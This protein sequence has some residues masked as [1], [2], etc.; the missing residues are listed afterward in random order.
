MYF[1]VEMTDCT[2][3]IFFNVSYHRSFIILDS[4][5]TVSLWN[6]MLRK[7]FVE[8]CLEIYIRSPFDVYRTNQRLQP[9]APDLSKFPNT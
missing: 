1:D 9:I 3:S 2:F 8:Y 4:D 7:V 6:G 5:H